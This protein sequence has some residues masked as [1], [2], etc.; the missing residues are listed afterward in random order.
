MC[1]VG[2]G[3]RHVFL[4]F[5]LLMSLKRTN[6]PFLWL[7]FAMLYCS[8]PLWGQPKLV[9]QA[10]NLFDQGKYVEAKNCIDQASEDAQ[11]QKKPSTWY[12][13]GVI[14]EQLMRKNMALAIA[15]TYLKEAVQAYQKTLSLASK[16][17]Q[18][19]SFANINLKGLWC[20]YLNRGVRYYKTGAFE[21][22]IEQFELCK[23]LAPENPYAFLYTAIARQQ[24]AKYELALEQYQAYLQLQPRGEAAAYKALANLTACYSQNFALAQTI[25]EEAIYQYPWE[26]SLLEAQNNLFMQLK[27][28]EFQEQRYHAALNQNAA[29]PLLSFRLGYLYEQTG[30]LAEAAI[31]Y[32]KAVLLA[33]KQLEPVC[34]LGMVYYNQAA[35]IIQRAHAMPEAIYQ[36]TAHQLQLEVEDYLHKALNCFKQA[37]KLQHTNLF[38]AKQLYILYKRLGMSEKAQL[39]KSAIGRIKGGRALLQTF[40]KD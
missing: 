9:T 35:A 23:Q 37:R 17:T 33:P 29:N 13:R 38:I 24:E 34:R 14:Y 12:Y 30:N 21:Q 19:Q 7:L 5:Y 4:T 18:Y 36:Q 10:L 22:A 27:Q 28:L 8:N 6:S 2:S 3:L 39:M 26:V 25:L 11:L 16:N 40:A 15:P 32:Q 20:Y 31:Y 1:K